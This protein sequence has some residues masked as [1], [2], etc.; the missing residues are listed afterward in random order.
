MHRKKVDVRLVQKILDV[1]IKL[2][3]EKKRL[4]SRRKKAQVRVSLG[5]PTKLNS[6]CV[7]YLPTGAIPLDF[8]HF[9]TPMFHV[10]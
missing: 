9:Y 2:S 6:R 3:T 1:Y 7:T 5:K 4:D 10:N 8:E